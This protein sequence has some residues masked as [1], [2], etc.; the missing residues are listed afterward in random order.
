MSF[1]VTGALFGES[2]ITGITGIAGITGSP[3]DPVSS[4]FI[5]RLVV[6]SPS[7]SFV[8]AVV[9]AVLIAHDKLLKRLC[10]EPLLGI[11]FENKKARRVSLKLLNSWPLK[12]DVA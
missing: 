6:I 7:T 10:T 5:S 3:L 9:V 2:S 1:P 11:I 12:L 4:L 8:V